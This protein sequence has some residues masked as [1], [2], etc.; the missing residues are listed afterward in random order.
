MAGER[1][2]SEHGDPPISNDDDISLR[3]HVQRQIDVLRDTAAARIV[4]ERQHTDDKMAALQELLD[5]SIAELSYRVDQRFDTR[6]QSS[7]ELAAEQDKRYEQRFIAQELAV[8]L[9]LGRV[10]KEFHGHLS[11]VREEG[12]AALDAANTA[13]QKSETATERRF[14]GVNEFRQ[15]LGDQA[16]TFMPRKESDVRMEAISEKIEKNNAQLIAM[17]LQVNSRLDLT[18]GA[19]SGGREAV[20]DKRAGN[21]AVM[22]AVGFG[23]SILLALITVVGVLLAS[24]P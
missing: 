13:I 18:Q 20:Q 17:Q 10:D 14:E 24:K 21:A 9:A 22:A 2:A 3:E 19:S 5:R 15:Q 8:T 7:A 1:T 11:S 6:V 23:I 4:I 16:Q 12:R